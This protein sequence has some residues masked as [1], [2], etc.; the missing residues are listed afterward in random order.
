MFKRKSYI[1]NENGS[2]WLL[3][4]T[5]TV[6]LRYNWEHLQDFECEEG[7][8]YPIIHEDVEAILEACQKYL[9]EIN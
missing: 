2:L 7:V 8:A 3:V 6:L 4:D 5:D 1:T 9:A